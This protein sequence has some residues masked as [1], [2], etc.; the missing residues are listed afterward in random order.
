VELVGGRV[1]QARVGGLR[2]AVDPDVAW[3]EEPAFRI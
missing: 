2:L 1:G 3:S